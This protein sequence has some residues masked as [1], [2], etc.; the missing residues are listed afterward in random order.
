MSNAA[1]LEAMARR[2]E[3]DVFGG[4]IPRHILHRTSRGTVFGVGLM[5]ESQRHGY[6]PSPGTLYR[7]LHAF[8]R[9]GYLRS[10]GQTVRGK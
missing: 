7:I 3:K 2:I 10:S 1:R 9:N 8:E 6:R 4:S 5:E